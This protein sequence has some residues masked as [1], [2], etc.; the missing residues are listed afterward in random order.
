[1]TARCPVRL[2]GNLQ[3]HTPCDETPDLNG[4]TLTSNPTFNLRENAPLLQR[5]FWSAG[6]MNSP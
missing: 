3:P 1:M 6:F 2:T 4:A 5:G